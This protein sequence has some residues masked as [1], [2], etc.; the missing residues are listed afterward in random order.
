MEQIDKKVKNLVMAMGRVES[1]GEGIKPYSAKGASGEY[2]RY[3]F[4]PT[5]W[6]LWSKEAGVSS[7][8]LKASPEEQN[9]VAYFKV[10]QFKDA[11]LNPAEIASKWNSGDSQAY[12]KNHRGVN[13]GGVNFDTPNHVRKVSAEYQNILA[14]QNQAIPP[15]PPPLGGSYQAPPTVKPFEPGQPFI[16]S[17]PAEEMYLNKVGQSL[18]RS[19]EGVGGAFNRSLSGQI[20]PASGVLQGTGAAAGLVGD[21]LDD[22]LTSLPVVGKAYETVT[23]FVGKG[24][25]GAAEATGVSD[26]FGRR[27]DEF[28][29]NVGAALNIAS[30]LP[31]FQALKY[32]KKATGDATTKISQ[33]KTE[34][35][36]GKE[37][38]ASLNQP[39]RRVLN[40][41]LEKGQDPMGLIISNPKY[42]P[43]MIKRNGRYYFD[44][45]AG[46][47]TLQK[48]LQADELA[49]QNLLKSNN[50]QTFNINSVAKIT[51]GDV[52]SKAGWTGN[53]GA[54]KSSLGKYFSE[55]RDSMQ[56]TDMINL[57]QLN[58]IKRDLR[59]AINFNMI[60][61]TGTLAKKAKYDGGNSLM[62]QVEEASGKREVKILNKEM[63]EKLAALDILEHLG[64]GKVIKSGP[65]GILQTLGKETPI[66]SGL[67]GLANRGAPRTPTSRLKNRSGIMKSVGRA[68]LNLGTGLALSSG[69]EEGR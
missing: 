59:K 8:H 44:T 2:G 28:Q 58:N 43:D 68:N 45:K 1:P 62:R 34:A 47:L 16:Q 23:D 54:L 40:R 66:V 32:G 10:K 33:K 17:D 39:Q 63:G 19:A 14:E 65:P 42:L 46:A 4:M 11:G 48:S 55:Y 37:L 30:I 26:W 50:R 61:P 49:L 6:K 69:Q 20:N 15:P 24:I 41:A 18:N 22:S 67:V 64:D 25:G 5:T 36:A 52:L 38:E 60:D 21:V 31:F 56:G 53:Y 7:P 57:S 35:N 29:G 9:R 27:S 13:A 3:Q 51:I 12:K